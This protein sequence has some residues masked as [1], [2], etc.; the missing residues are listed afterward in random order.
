MITPRTPIIA[1]LLA[2]TGLHAGTLAMPDAMSAPAESGWSFRFAPY[3][4]L[5]AIDGDMG[6]GP[7]TAPVDISFSDTLDKLDMAYMFLAEAGY[8]RWTLTADFVYGDFSNETAG[9]FPIDRISYGYTQWVLTSSVGYRVI[10]TDGY[11]MDVFAGARITDFDAGATAFLLNNTQIQSGRSDQ[12]TDPIIG[13]RGQADLNERFVLRYN[14]D[15]GGFGVSSDLI[16][17][18][19]LGLG[20]RMTDHATVAIGYRALG[21]DYT[22]DEFSPLDVINHGPLLG[23]EFRF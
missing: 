7:F 3:A 21:V 2:A 14:A 16:W 15:I 20:Y 23:L 9:P 6:V 5:I 10:Q 1:S 17:Q 4:W 8:G 19:F 18:A 11:A 12:W 22:S 13:I